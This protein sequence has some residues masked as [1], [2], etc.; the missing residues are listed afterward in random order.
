MRDKR[1]MGVPVE[2][3]VLLFC[4]V[5]NTVRFFWGGNVEGKRLSPRLD[6]ISGGFQ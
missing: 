6:S 1:H 4:A 2:R 5:E 3:D